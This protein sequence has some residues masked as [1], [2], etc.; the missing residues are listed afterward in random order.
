M[1]VTKVFVLVYLLLISIIDSKTLC[2]PNTILLSL[3][4]SVFFLDIK[5]AYYLIPSKL[6]T[7]I[8]FFLIFFGIALF[9]KGLGYGDVKLIAILGYCTSFFDTIIIG[10]IAS[11]IGLLYFLLKYIN[12]QKLQK[13]AFAPFLSIGYFLT[14]LFK[15][16]LQ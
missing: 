3:F 9:T 13:I 1:L 2:I 5:H 4:S 11:G 10:L 6:I 14:E 8:L 7:G 15:R 12:K 16:C